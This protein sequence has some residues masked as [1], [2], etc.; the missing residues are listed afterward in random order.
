MVSPA[1]VIIEG[2]LLR[3]YRRAVLAPPDQD[4]RPTPPQQEM[5]GLR[6]LKVDFSL[7]TLK[8]NL[9]FADSLKETGLFGI[10][11]SKHHFNTPGETYSTV[12]DEFPIVLDAY[13]EQPFVSASLERGKEKASVLDAGIGGISV[14]AIN[15]TVEILF[16]A[17]FSWVTFVNDL[18]NIVASYQARQL[19]QNQIFLAALASCGGPARWAP[20]PAFI[21]HPSALWTLGYRPFQSSSA[22]RLLHR[23]RYRLK[24]LPPADIDRR[25]AE[26]SDLGARELWTTLMANLADNHTTEAVLGANGLLSAVFPHE[27]AVALPPV[28]PVAPSPEISLLSATQVDAKLSFGRVGLLIYEYQSEDNALVFG[29]AT[30]GLR[31]TNNVSGEEVQSRQSTSDGHREM[32]VECH[33]ALDKIGISLNPNMLAFSKHVLRVYRWFL[34]KGKGL[35]AEDL[36]ASSGTIVEHPISPTSSLVPP[37]HRVKLHG[38]FRVGTISVKASAHNV[39]AQLKITAICASIAHVV[40]LARGLDVPGDVSEAAPAPFHSTLGRFSKLRGLVMEKGYKTDSSGDVQLIAVD[41]GDGFI[42]ATLAK[43]SATSDARETACLLLGSKMAVFKVPQSLL[44]LYTF[45]EKWRDDNLPRYDSLINEM[46]KQL[47][48][49]VAETQNSI[50]DRYVPPWERRD[51]RI[52]LSLKSIGLQLDLLSNLRI[53]YD[54]LDVLGFVDTTM[55]TG[56]SR[57]PRIDIASRIAKQELR[58]QTRAKGGG[59]NDTATLTRFNPQ[60]ATIQNTG[61]SLPSIGGFCAITFPDRAANQRGP[62]MDTSNPPAVDAYVVID[63]LNAPISV[64][65]ID[66]F[67]T[68]QSVV[69]NEVNDLLDTLVLSRRRAGQGKP[70]VTEP[71]KDEPKAVREPARFALKIVFEEPRVEA[72]SPSAAVVVGAE[73]LE[74]FV[75]N[76]GDELHAIQIVAH[77]PARPHLF[78]KFAANGLAFDVMQ[79][80]PDAS[81]TSDEVQPS[82]KNVDRS[83]KLATVAS[84]ISLSNIQNRLDGKTASPAESREA[85]QAALDEFYAGLHRLHIVMQPTALG[86]ILDFGV[87]YSMELERRKMQRT[88]DLEKLKEST[89]LFLRSIDVDLP[90]TTATSTSIFRNKRI[91]LEVNRIAAVIPLDEPSDRNATTSAGKLTKKQGVKAFMGSIHLLTL[92]TSNLDVNRGSLQEICFQFIHDFDQD[93]EKH[94]N[95]NT[96]MSV[97]NR[98]RLRVPEISGDV[99]VLK[100]QIEQKF[101]ANGA[102]SGFECELD[103][104]ISR[105]VNAMI[106]VWRSSR[107]RMLQ[108]L[109]SSA[110]APAPKPQ[111][112]APADSNPALAPRP[113][114]HTATPVVLDIQATF[115]FRNGGSIRIFSKGRRATGAN[116]SGASKAQASKPTSSNS[117]PTQTASWSAAG[118]ASQAG[119]RGNDAE[120][121]GSD[122]L[123]HQVTIPGLELSL[124]SKTLLGG[125]GTITDSALAADRDLRRMHVELLIAKS[126]NTFFPSIITFFNE[127]A[128]NVVVGSGGSLSGGAGGSN[129]SLG[130]VRHQRNASIGDLTGRTVPR[131]TSG[132]D[133]AKGIDA[134]TRLRED[135]HTISVYFRLDNTRVDLSCQPVQSVTSAFEIERSH[136]LFFFTR[137]ARLNLSASATA[138]VGNISCRV[139]HAYG[140]EDSAQGSVGSVSLNAAMM[141]KSGVFEYAFQL[142]VP[143]VSASMNFRF[144]Q[145]IFFLQTCWIPAKATEGTPIGRPACPTQQEAASN[146]PTAPTGPLHARRQSRVLGSLSSLASGAGGSFRN[147]E[148]LS[149]ASTSTKSL[150]FGSDQGSSESLST[151]P[152]VSIRLVAKV[153]AIQLGAELGHAIGKTTLDWKDTVIDWR[154]LDR[155]GQLPKLGGLL[156]IS[157]ISMMSEGRLAGRAAMQGLRLEVDSAE[158]SG[159]AGSRGGAT[160][161][162]KLVE[163]LFCIFGVQAIQGNYEYQFERVLLLDGGLLRASIVRE[164]FDAQRSLDCSLKVVAIVDSLKAIA[165]RRTLPTVMH[166]AGTV[167]KIIEEKQVYVRSKFAAPSQSVSGPKQDLSF[168]FTGARKSESIKRVATKVYNLVF[169]VAGRVGQLR[170]QVAIIVKTA[171]I[172][173][174]RYNFRDTD[175]ALANLSGLEL[176]LDT[177]RSQDNRDNPKQ[178]SSTTVAALQ[179]LKT[180]GSAITASQERQ[181]TS[182]EWFEHVEKFKGIPVLLLPKFVMVL[183]S[184]TR[185]AT[186]VVEYSFNADFAGAVDVAL[187]FALYKYLIELANLYLKALKTANLAAE[188][189]RSGS[190]LSLTVPAASAVGGRSLEALARDGGG[191]AGG[192]T[193]LLEVASNRS[194]RSSEAGDAPDSVMGPPQATVS[195]PVPSLLSSESLSTLENPTRFVIVGPVKFEP[196]LRVMGDATPAE[197]LEYLGVT[198]DKV[199]RVVYGIVTENFEVVFAAA[200]AIAAILA[201]SADEGALPILSRRTS[202]F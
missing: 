143:N 8:L 37:A 55:T 129:S 62:S 183:E 135:H 25:R 101:R 73:T 84:D 160:D 120:V 95:P 184:V 24:L 156:S 178:T 36:A 80:L 132:G 42:E 148:P 93:N 181:W 30:V 194:D 99:I 28:P 108:V 116:A 98:N 1:D 53:A 35:E 155:P 60:A 39:F 48:A 57:K 105:Y 27:S 15:Q 171:S 151:V 145:D 175:S 12:L 119:R 14:T 164:W 201:Q 6:D 34:F 51:F 131:M 65:M 168:G 26:L 125:A 50:V 13:I 154:R 78:W 152:T 188:S 150:D 22:W 64:S 117:K 197:W 4:P 176:R 70:T 10:P 109:P 2:I 107:D 165:S 133:V 43:G 130:G 11:S 173:L 19:R 124:R 72:S 54:V 63:S 180:T 16:G 89:T 111:G 190:S 118:S 91:F 86:K 192:G 110:A 46:I 38:A 77:R 122:Q 170:G 138:R 140:S 169:P 162:S 45:M 40:E 92:A 161:I 82:A 96:H 79:H 141:P 18:D 174:F 69:G 187:N 182:K 199:P 198:K 83:A 166:V 29:P 128:S 94:F 112:L 103:S 146:A 149:S 139:R 134:I 85:S 88:A 104:S 153:G 137:D 158:P 195:A 41:V 189:G 21:Q 58:F 196:Q 121:R 67:L 9:R 81:P 32:I 61:F 202:T 144:L 3:T 97:L 179:V 49:P 87:F 127:I 106:S 74:G 47:D 23:L 126:E 44:K 75:T 56:I 100:E 163:D 193:G 136:V 33:G 200:C 113:G 102:V 191:G 71:T 17:A 68:A 90:K 177:L 115:Q 5:P 159:G 185:T 59:F 147:L 20:D 142:L 114:D 7:A 157:E 123:V 66:H 167:A 172:T 52:Q 31:L 76:R 186:R